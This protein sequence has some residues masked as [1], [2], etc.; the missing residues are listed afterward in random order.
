[1]TIN[2]VIID[3]ETL[4]TAPTAVILSIGAFAFDRF[5]LNETLENIKN[6]SIQEN[7]G[8]HHLY[9]VCNLNDQLILSKR[10]ISQSTINW[11]RDQSWSSIK[12]LFFGNR[13]PKLFET[14]A[15]LIRKI[16]K[17][18]EINPK[19]MFYFRGADFDPVI[20]K[21]AF[22]EYGLPTPWEYYNVRDVRTYID[23]LSGDDSGYLDGHKLSFNY[24]KHNSLHD[25]M[26]DA[27]QMCAAAE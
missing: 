23:A 2:T 9:Y 14:L 18:T 8:P 25:A 20:L 19:I 12:P 21:N 16:N 11:W 15:F 7:E 27:E 10:T 22:S 4:D 3:I 17:W 24:I 5:D 1:M 13:Q 6:S 26:R